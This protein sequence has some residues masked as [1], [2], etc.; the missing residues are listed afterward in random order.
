MLPRSTSTTPRLVEV[1]LAQQGFFVA[2]IVDLM[3]EHV[4]APAD[5]S[6]QWREF[7]QTGVCLEKGFHPP[8]VG[9]RKAAYAG[10]V[11]P[12]IGGELLHHGFTPAFNI[13]PLH[14]DPPAC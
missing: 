12:Q 9:R 2:L 8:G 14:D 3:N 13:L 11:C 10:K 4:L 7:F 6:H 1:G 5:F